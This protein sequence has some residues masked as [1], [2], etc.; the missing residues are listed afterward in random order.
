M[1]ATNSK[2]LANKYKDKIKSDPRWPA[3]SMMSG[4]QKE[5]KLMFSRFQMYRA[6]GKVAKMVLGV[7]ISNM[8]CCGCM[9]QRL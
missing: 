3:D 6:K 2:W 4:M 8:V 7:R 1:S 5:C 9:P